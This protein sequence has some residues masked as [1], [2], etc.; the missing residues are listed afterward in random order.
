MKREVQISSYFSIPLDLAQ[1]LG[2]W[3]EFQS[4]SGYNVDLYNVYTHERVQIRYVNGDDNVNFISIISE[5]PGFLFD[6][7]LGEVIYSMS[8]HND[9]LTVKRWA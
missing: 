5:Q 4:G 7:V 6:G 2:H 1:Q 3:N 8:E 9:N